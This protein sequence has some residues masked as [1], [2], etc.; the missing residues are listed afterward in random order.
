MTKFQW[1]MFLVG[2][3]VWLS[4]GIVLG[5]TA[6]A[7]AHGRKSASGYLKNA[8]RWVVALIAFTVGA[9]IGVLFSHWWFP[10][11]SQ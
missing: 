6:W 10:T 2:G 11:A 4:M 5:W 7:T 9:G 1:S 3:A 8:P